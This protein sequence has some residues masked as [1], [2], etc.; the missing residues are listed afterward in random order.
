MSHVRSSDETSAHWEAI[1][2][3]R[4]PTEVSWYQPHLRQSLDLIH[5]AGLAREAAVIDVGGGTSTLV[6]DLL[7]EGFHNLTV[8]DISAKALQATKARLGP[9]AAQVT[10]IEGDV[11]TTT[12]PAEHYGLWHD[13]ALF[14]FLLMPE[15]QQ[16]YVAQLRRAVKPAGTVILSTFGPKAPPRC[17][18]LEVVRYSPEALERAFGGLLRLVSSTAEQHRTPFGTTQEFIYCRFVKTGG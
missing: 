13:R 15:D 17:S 4:Q 11:L 2:Q 8:L 14:H 3:R 5:E 7:Q 16:G 18:G 9:Q 1:F 12:L 10:W 6:D